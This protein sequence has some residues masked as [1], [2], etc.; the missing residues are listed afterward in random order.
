MT[1]TDYVLVAVVY[2]L[3]SITSNCLFFF[4]FI[5]KAEKEGEPFLKDVFLDKLFLFLKQ[6]NSQLQWYK[7]CRMTYENIVHRVLSH[8]TRKLFKKIRLRFLQDG[9]IK[10]QIEKNSK[11]LFLCPQILSLD[12]ILWLPMSRV[13]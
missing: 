13:E 9:L 11:L 7:L 10:R 4:F 6:S 8:S 12:S 2:R 1:L 3:P 5:V